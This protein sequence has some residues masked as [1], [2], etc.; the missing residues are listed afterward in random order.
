MQFTAVEIQNMAKQKYEV[1]ATLAPVSKSGK[2]NNY[3][4]HRIHI[5][6]ITKLTTQTDIN[7][8]EVPISI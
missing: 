4:S 7:Y 3:T 2:C 5:F 6:L 1:E 8:S